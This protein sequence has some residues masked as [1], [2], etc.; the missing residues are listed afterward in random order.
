VVKKAFGHLISIALQTY[1]TVQNGSHRL[2]NFCNRYL[3]PVETGRRTGKIEKLIG[4]VFSWL[5]KV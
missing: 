5:K 2:K 1:S 3:N 4:T